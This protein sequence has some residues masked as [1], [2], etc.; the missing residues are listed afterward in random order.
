M[1][2]SK[3]P[4]F[5]VLPSVINVAD[6]I[7]HFLNKGRINFPDEVNLGN[8]IS[9][10]FHT[11]KPVSEKIEL[12]SL[13]T[14][15]IRN[16]IDNSEN[17][18][19]SPEKIV[20]ILDASGIKRA[21]EAV[22]NSKEEALEKANALGLPVVMKVVGPVHK[23]DVGGVV[24][25]VKSN[26][27]IISE[28]ERMI[29]IKDTTAILIQPMLSG[30]ELFV[31]AKREDKFGHMVL[32]GL[33]GIFIEVLEDVNAGLAPL[34][35][36]E[37]ETMIKSL[38]SYKIIKGVRGQEGVNEEMFAEIVQRVS[39]LV[40]VAPEIFEMDLNPLLGSK[41]K[42]VAVDARIRIEK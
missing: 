9:K 10:V 3:K 13:N 34:S 28:F 26:E 18:Y 6:E 40:T 33:G 36:Q 30:T 4:I 29:K 19:L 22:V 35:I 15:K 27:T 38:N 1:K 37:A 41:N 2:T 7:T 25:N 8:A 17:G 31:G 16:I 20:E 21:G 39:A 11:K 12:P 5:P 32:C 42:V 14:K 24:L 23:S